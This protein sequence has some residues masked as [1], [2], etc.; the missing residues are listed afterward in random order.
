MKRFQFSLERVMAWRRLQAQIEESALEK[1]HADLRALVSRVEQVSAGR[2]R[3]GRELART[4]SA[5]ATELACLDSFQRAADAEVERLR[6]AQE[7]CRSRIQA[8]VA[9]VAGRRR[10]LRMLERLKERK[11][12][13]WNRA[14]EREIEEQAAETHL[15]R[16]ARR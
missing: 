1:L 16:L 14:S 2:A 8:Q 15:A 7:Q 4:G 13:E 10:D 6:Q 5:T 3:A 12:A 9:R 11:F